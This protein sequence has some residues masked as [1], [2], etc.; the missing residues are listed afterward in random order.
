[1]PSTKEVP[2]TVQTSEPAALTATREAHVAALNAGD[3]E[4]WVACFAA[5]AVQMPP[6]LPANV[7]VAKIQAW[8][9]AFLG[10]FELEFALDPRDVQMT[11]SGWAF[12]RGAYKIGLTPKGGGGA[13]QDAGKYITVY[14][15]EGDGS[16]VM[17]Q[18]IW[19]S[20]SPPPSAG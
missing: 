8:S 17:A 20:D 2:M 19:N 10:A 13:M 18:D 11:G 5:D 15:R 9:S 3:A 1:M 14:R 6:N 7:G 4:G 12:E 16:W